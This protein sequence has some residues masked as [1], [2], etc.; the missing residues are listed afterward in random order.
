MR[1]LKFIVDDQTLSQDS[2]CDFEGLVP[3]TNGYLQAEF[4]FS[5]EWNGCVKVV[6][7]YSVLGK[8]YTPQLLKDGK[9]CTIPAEALTKRVFKLRVTGKNKDG[10]TIVTNKL[11]I[12]Q[13]G[14]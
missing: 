5:P 12:S 7:F 13:K 3:G 6:S 1:K 14:V 2:N 8:E 4:A 11:A 10:S 9:S